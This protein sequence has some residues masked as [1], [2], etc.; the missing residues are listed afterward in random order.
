MNGVFQSF[1]LI[2]SL[3]M[4]SLFQ[5]SYV[6]HFW[7]V[8]TLSK[9]EYS[10][11]TF[12]ENKDRNFLLNL[13]KVGGRIVSSKPSEVII[14][15]SPSSGKLFIKPI[16]VKQSSQKSSRYKSLQE[17]H[18]QN[19]KTKENDHIFDLSA[20]KPYRFQLQLDNPVHLLRLSQKT[21]KSSYNNTIG[22][23][24]VF[25]IPPAATPSLSTLLLLVVFPQFLFWFLRY[26]LYFN[27][28]MSL[29]WVVLIDV[30]LQI[31]Y[32]IL[33]Q[34]TLALMTSL[35]VICLILMVLKQYWEKKGFSYYLS[36]LGVCLVATHLRWQEILMQSG[37]P[38]NLFEKS[39]LYYHQALALDLFSENGFYAAKSY[40]DPFYPL[41]I[42]T[43]GWI[44][45]FAPFYLFYI[46]L[47]WSLC[48]IALSFWL[49]HLIFNS[50]AKA[51]FVALALSV[52]PLMLQESGLREPGS[53]LACL[54]VLSLIISYLK[55]RTW[56]LQGLLKGGLYLIW[57]LTHVGALP[58]IVLLSIWDFYQQVRRQDVQLLFKNQIKTL[59]L[60]SVLLCVGLLPYLYKSYIEH[61]T[62]FSESTHYISRI[63]NL[64]FSDQ[65]GFPNSIDLSLQ[66]EKAKLYR[67]ISPK[68][69]FFQYHTF[70]KFFGAALL[71]YLAMTMDALGNL[72]GLAR[73]QNMIEVLTDNLSYSLDQQLFLI[74]FI[75]ESILAGFLCAWVWVKRRKYLSLFTALIIVMLPYSFFY[76]LF[77]IKGLSNLQL[78]LDIQIFIYILPL[79]A[80]LL[81]GFFSDILN[82]LKMSST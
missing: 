80:I 76:G 81:V 66:G 28:A 2:F 63:A 23:L 45:S 8:D 73:G 58:S 48:L 72:F 46:S 49:A 82:Y 31:Q 16:I 69:Y 62:V 70:W 24:E 51:I 54:F 37:I 47:F 11:L 52:N 55:L 39:S 57:G 79:F 9:S 78:L 30:G 43:S 36:V 50:K 10:H 29:F 32:Q 35:L 25:L 41:M 33:P 3:G 13:E 59:V 15:F 19:P 56:W 12:F 77:L 74:Q 6:K 27:P 4:V 1:I 7:S 42:K 71:G 65:H 21:Q 75:V 67:Q 61:Q 14:Q 64:E 20:Q 18:L 26:L 17:I 5:W 34:S 40:L 60:I 53:F 68:E 44:L 22:G 38:F